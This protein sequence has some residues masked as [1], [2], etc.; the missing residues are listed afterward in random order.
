MLQGEHSAILST[1]IKLPFGIKI[2]FCLF[3]SGSFTQVL[4]YHTYITF[5]YG[6]R[7]VE[8]TGLTINDGVS[9][10]VTESGLNTDYWIGE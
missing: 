2:V 9:S 10:M 3:W 5:R 8:P 1:F 7:L 4:L 6:A